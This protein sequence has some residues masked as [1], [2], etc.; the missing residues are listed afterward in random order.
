MFHKDKYYWDQSTHFYKNTKLDE[1]R[2]SFLQS[3]TRRIEK[4][5]LDVSQVDPVECF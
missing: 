4:K 1:I 3:L 2:R 5:N